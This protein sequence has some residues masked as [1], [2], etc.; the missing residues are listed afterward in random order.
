MQLTKVLSMFAE[1]FVPV[2]NVLQQCINSDMVKILNRLVNKEF[3][4]LIESRSHRLLAVLCGVID[5][6]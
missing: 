6:V 4:E 5:V 3:Q 2:W 1:F